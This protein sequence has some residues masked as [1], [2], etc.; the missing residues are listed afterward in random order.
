MLILISLGT[1]EGM[2]QQPKRP[3]LKYLG[4]LENYWFLLKGGLKATYMFDKIEQT[5]VQFSKTPVV[6][7]QRELNF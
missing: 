1:S 4:L 7:W 5:Q 6:P 3:P 2:E